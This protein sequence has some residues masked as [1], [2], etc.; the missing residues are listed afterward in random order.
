MFERAVQLEKSSGIAGVPVGYLLTSAMNN[1]F[2]RHLCHVSWTYF[3]P[4]PSC[5]PCIGEGSL[6]HFVD[7]IWLLVLGLWPQS[8]AGRVLIVTYPTGRDRK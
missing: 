4:M 1:T 7:I 5:K 6:T 8:L 2:E 3:F